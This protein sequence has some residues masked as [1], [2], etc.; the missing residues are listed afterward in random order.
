MGQIK[1]FGLRE[2]I[3]P[4]QQELSAVIHSCLVDAFKFPQNK[5]FQRFMLLNREDFIFPEERSANYLII[6]ISMFEGRSVSAKKELV[7]LL[8]KRIQEKCNISPQD[9]EIALF[10]TPKCNWGIRGLSGD[11]LA[12]NYKVEV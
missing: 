9:V 6:E 5:K 11:E 1:V 4:I 2:K 7:H 8:F 10:E 12:L 3:A